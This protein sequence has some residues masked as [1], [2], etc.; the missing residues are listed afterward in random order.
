MRQGSIDLVQNEDMTG[1][2]TS[3][4]VNL[5][6][7]YSYSIQAYWAGG[8]NP[9]GLFYLQGSND[10]GDDGSGQAVSDPVNW[11]IVGGSPVPINGTPG[12]ITY[13]VASCGYRWVRLQY[14]P[15]SGSAT[16]NVTLNVKG[17]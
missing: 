11:T 14:V 17:V 8:A 13:D 3:E 5:I 9:S 4:P 1:A 10:P 15:T 7:I 12:S 16:I 2:V 6:S